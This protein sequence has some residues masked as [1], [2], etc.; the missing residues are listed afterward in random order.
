MPIPEN[1]EDSGAGEPG[2][3]AVTDLLFQGLRFIFGG[4]DASKLDIISREPPV[5]AGR[6]S[7]VERSTNLE[8]E[9]SG[10]GEDRRGRRL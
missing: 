4:V 6:L 10:G 7:P 1:L 2:V 9:K 5:S 8:W 3:A